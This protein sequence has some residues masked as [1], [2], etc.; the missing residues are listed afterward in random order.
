MFV[1]SPIDECAQDCSILPAGPCA[2]ALANR[3]AGAGVRTEPRLR[4]A[5]W[6][7]SIGA[8]AG[9]GEV[10]LIETR[11]DL[12]QASHVPLASM[13]Q[14]KTV[15]L[16]AAATRLTCGWQTKFRGRRNRSTGP[17]VGNGDAIAGRSRPRMADVECS[18]LEVMSAG[19]GRSEH[20]GRKTAKHHCT[21][22]GDS[23]GKGGLRDDCRVVCHETRAALK[24]VQCV[25][26]KSDLIA[27]G[28]VVRP[29]CKYHR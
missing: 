7:F 2:S 5:C 13:G 23:I 27:A 28:V 17:S 10:K 25:K 19:A 14:L 18:C 24:N 20:G 16:K 21:S 1:L 3:T 6:T 15:V 29:K 9:R 26:Q 22:R 12:L 8:R 11:R 4:R